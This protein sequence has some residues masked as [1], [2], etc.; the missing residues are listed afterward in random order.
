MKCAK[1]LA[2]VKLQSVEL[3]GIYL[4]MLYVGCNI[5]P[6]NY[7]M[8]K[9]NLYNNLELRVITLNNTAI[10]TAAHFRLKL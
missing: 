5:N 1:V 8:L 7:I 10:F 2:A 6:Q 9:Y 3:S 4:L